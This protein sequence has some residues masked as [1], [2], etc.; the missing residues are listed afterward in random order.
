MT[1]EDPTAQRLSSLERDMGV[2][3]GD[4]EVVKSDL[5]GVKDDLDVVKADINVLKTDMSLIK[6]DMGYMKKTLAKME[7]ALESLLEMKAIM[8]HM[9]TTK[10]VEVAKHMASKT[11]YTALGSLLFA[12]VALGLAVI[13]LIR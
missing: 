2:V 12:L 13:P 9:A 11:I 1:N 8:P 5:E 4:L 3:K 7:D 10:D 6:L